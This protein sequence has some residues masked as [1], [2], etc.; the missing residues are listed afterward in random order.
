MVGY[1]MGLGWCLTTLLLCKKS[2]GEFAAGG[3]VEGPL[4]CISLAVGGTGTVIRNVAMWHVCL[5][6]W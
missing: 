5:Q 2:V 1:G 4:W 3:L 6:W